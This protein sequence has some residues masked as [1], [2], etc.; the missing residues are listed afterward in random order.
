MVHQFVVSLTFCHQKNLFCFLYRLFNSVKLLKIPLNSTYIK[1]SYRSQEVMELELYPYLVAFIVEL[2]IVIF[3]KI[4]DTMKPFQQLI[5]NLFLD[6]FG[7][8]VHIDFPFNHQLKMKLVFQYFSFNLILSHIN[9]L[10]H[11]SLLVL[12]L[13]TFLVPLFFHSHNYVLLLILVSD[14]FTLVVIIHFHQILNLVHWT[15]CF[16]NILKRYLIEVY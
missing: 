16:S 12:C 4:S 8:Q 10:D 5:K 1:L 3:V 13:I 6:H 15:Y 14:L 2:F 9:F 7:F 11:P